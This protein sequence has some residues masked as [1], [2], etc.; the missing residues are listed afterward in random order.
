MDELLN[1]NTAPETRVKDLDMTKPSEFKKKETEVTGKV[2]MDI[3]DKICNLFPFFAKAGTTYN[4][5]IRSKGKDKVFN[6]PEFAALRRILLNDLLALKR[7]LKNGDGN[8]ALV[9]EQCSIERKNSIVL[10]NK[11]QL[12]V[13]EVIREVE[14]TCRY[15]NSYFVNAS[16]ENSE[17]YRYLT[18]VQVD[19]NDLENPNGESITIAKHELKA[20]FDKWDIKESYGIVVVPEL[21]KDKVLLKNWSR[22][23]SDFY[24]FL[25]TDYPD[26]NDF[27]IDPN[28]W[29]NR[30]WDSLNDPKPEE[31][32]GVG[33]GEQRTI[34][35]INRSVF[36]KAYTELGEEKPVYLPN[37]LALVGKMCNSE[38]QKAPAG[39]M[40][41]GI[42]GAY[43]VTHE[44]LRS[45]TELMSGAKDGKNPGWQLISATNDFGN[46][47]FIGV[48]TLCTGKPEYRLFPIMRLNDWITKNIGNYLSG[49]T[50]TTFDTY[51]E[52][53][54]IKE[55]RRFL[56]QYTGNGKPLSKYKI[57]YVEPNKVKP[58]QIDVSID[59][60]PWAIVESF[61]LS[62]AEYV[63]PKEEAAK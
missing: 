59:C 10:F 40:Q 19:G 15:V 11:K 33:N 49:Q 46:P 39:K 60:F 53:T 13:L 52:E 5:A 62:V 7:I 47:V 48:S 34:V 9:A 42:A 23:V 18:V 51:L 22:V 38:I 44:L 3:Y 12:R 63:S 55:L 36:R 37:S 57:N 45:E 56:N 50:F 54:I 16:G 29:Q 24:A 32:P 4:F 21:A 43:G 1:Q 27:G 17:A 26:L 41:G 31:L 61:A 58:T 20:R 8:P 35:T 30:D 25:V 28:N 14:E 6:N 2:L